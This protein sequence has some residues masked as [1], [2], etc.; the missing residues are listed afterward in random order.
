MK[1]IAY[2]NGKTGPIDEMMVPMND[3]A[4]YFG[5]GVYD[6]SYVFNHIPMAIDEHIDRIYRSAGLIDIHIRQT[7]EEFKQEY[8]RLS[9]EMFDREVEQLDNYDKAAVMATLITEQAKKLREENGKRDEGQKKVYY[10]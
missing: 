10:F 3:R 7:K 1:D 2:Y 4:C 6:V 5:D 8:S 9:T